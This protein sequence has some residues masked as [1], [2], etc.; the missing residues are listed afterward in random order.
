MSPIV[1]PR[2]KRV[3]IKLQRYGPHML[4]RACATQLLRTGSSL[5]EIADFLG[6]SDLRSVGSYAKF[7]PESLKNVAK[8]SLRGVL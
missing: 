3:G 1:N 8:F 6:H 7:D 4:R 2:M 5:K